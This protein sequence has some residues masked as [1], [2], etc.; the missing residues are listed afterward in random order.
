MKF[1]LNI[2]IDKNDNESVATKGFNDIDEMFEACSKH[3][4]SDR[5][6]QEKVKARNGN[7]HTSKKSLL[8][9][10]KSIFSKDGFV[11]F[12]WENK[13]TSIHYYFVFVTN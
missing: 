11:M 8:A 4:P 1:S 7:L 13:N 2:T 6:I 5:Y 12:D 10:L 9:E 3:L